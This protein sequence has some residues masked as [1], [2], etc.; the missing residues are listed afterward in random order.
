MDSSTAAP[1]HYTTAPQ[2]WSL[3]GALSSVT[4]TRRTSE[5]KHGGLAIHAA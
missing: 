1:S 3:I 4:A 5:L 2:A